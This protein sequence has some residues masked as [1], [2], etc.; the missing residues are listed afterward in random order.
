MKVKKLKKN[1]S[2]ALPSLF[3]LVVQLCPAVP[4][5]AQEG[6]AH[7]Q[8]FVQ[9][10][11]DLRSSDRATERDMLA[12]RLL[13]AKDAL[14]CL[15]EAEEVHWVIWLM[16]QEMVALNGLQRYAEAQ[17]VVDA[18]F[19]T[20]TTR[21]DSSDVARFYMWDLRFKHFDGRFTEALESY[22]HPLRPEAARGVVQAVLAQR[23]V[24]LYG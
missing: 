17:A 22:R 13:A 24:S 19:R 5:S 3:L 4:A 23:R 9:T 18:F 21:A 11:I 2:I 8:G 7:C 6:L 1:C 15:E 20:Y 10:V 16:H 12:S 14:S